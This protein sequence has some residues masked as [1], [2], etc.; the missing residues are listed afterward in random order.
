MKLLQLQEARYVGP[1]TFH[2]LLQ[3]FT[4]ERR[5]AAP[6][7]GYYNPRNEV[8]IKNVV[9]EFEY[10]GEEDVRMLIVFH[11][12]DQ[13]RI[14]YRDTDQTV[15]FDEAVERLAVFGLKRIF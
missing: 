6:D 13:V 5:R 12:T 10:E 1:K 2:N 15:S 3:Y 11:D 8:A 7:R 14:F 4:E 9:D